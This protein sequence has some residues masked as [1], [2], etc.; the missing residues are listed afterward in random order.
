[1]FVRGSYRKKRVA[2]KRATTTKKYSKK[3]TKVSSK[4]TQAIKTVIKREAETKI[5]SAEMVIPVGSFQQSS[6]LNVRTL[7][8]SSAY[9]P[10]IQGTSQD[11]RIANK[12]QTKRVVLRYILHP[13]PYN[14][15]TNTANCP[16]DVIMWIGRM[17]RSV[18][19]PTAVDFQ[20]FFQ[21]GSSSVAPVGDLSDING[22]INKDYFTVDKKI[23]HKIGFADYSGTSINVGAHSY[24]NN[25]YKYNV[26]RSVDLTKCFAKNY[27]FN[28]ADNDP[29]NSRTYIWFESVRAD[30]ITGNAT[31]IP[32]M[33]RGT[34]DFMY[35]DV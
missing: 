31:N 32:V 35:C 27:L 18:S 21:F 15:S 30:G 16:Q 19:S 22:V 3:N 6:V 5:A 14:A 7:S 4:L 12:I 9:M 20:N 24:T 33:F 23:V 26:V 8:P 10:I 25:D 34:L 17:K 13:L 28:D 29:Q 2:R 1:M 11:E